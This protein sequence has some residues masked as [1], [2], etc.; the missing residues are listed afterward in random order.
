ML[1]NVNFG[2]YLIIFFINLL[3][4]YA[5]FCCASVC[6]V[7][8]TVE[9]TQSR[10]VCR[11]LRTDASRLLTLK[12]R[13][14]PPPVPPTNHSPGALASEAPPHTSPPGH[15]TQQS[16]MTRQSHMTQ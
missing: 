12:P 5:S 7:L 2:T 11:P 4:L 10:G 1:L 14:N 13:P 9:L 8:F 6:F 3:I 15:M 16:H